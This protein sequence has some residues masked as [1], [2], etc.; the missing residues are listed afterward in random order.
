MKKLNYLFMFL[1]EGNYQQTY[2][3]QET[4]HFN[5]RKKKDEKQ[6]ADLFFLPFF[7]RSGI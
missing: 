1:K 5:I 2:V 4:L 6:F 3:Y 7:W